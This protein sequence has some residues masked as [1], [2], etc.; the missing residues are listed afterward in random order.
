MK[1]LIAVV[2]LVVAVYGVYRWQQAPTDGPK[3]NLV[4]NR[5]WIDHMPTSERDPFHLFGA[6]KP[7]SQ[8]GFAVETRWHGEVERFRFEAEGDEL[9]AV[10]PWKGDRETIRVR[11]YRC[12]END[13]DFCLEMTGSKRGTQKYYSRTGWERGSVEDVD[14]FR[15]SLFQ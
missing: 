1:K 9:R 4:Y 7:Y 8:G 11:A 3:R 12:E 15:A 5:M 6:F 13:M 10:F 14:A 2:V